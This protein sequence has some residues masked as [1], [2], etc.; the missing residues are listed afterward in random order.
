MSN[1]HV[2]QK[3]VCIVDDHGQSQLGE[4]TETH[5]PQKGHV[6]TIAEIE[7]F[8]GGTRM[9]FFVLPVDTC[10]LTL[11]ECGRLSSFDADHFRPVVTRKTSIEIFRRIL[12]NPH[13]RIEEDA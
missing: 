5:W 12:A 10:F 13:I 6:Y 9:G 4:R 3:V 7:H 2:G 1:F 11:E 8:A